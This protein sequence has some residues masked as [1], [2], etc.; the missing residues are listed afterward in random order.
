MHM[1]V[2]AVIMSIWMRADQ[3]LMTGKMYFAKL[4]A[5]L[6]RTIYRQ[7]VVSSIARIEADDVMMAF[8]IAAL[9]I[10]VI[11]KVCAHA[12]NGEIFLTAVERRNA[13]ILSRNETT[14]AVEDGLHG[15]LVMLEDKIFLCVAIVG[16]FRAD[17][18]ERRQ[19][20]HQPFV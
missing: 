15:E 3:C 8:H 13:I 10:F 5:Q 18:F 20:H 2:A 4:L 19:S 7:A 9:S 17:M 11:A 12:G 16:I 1:D 14:V 6:L